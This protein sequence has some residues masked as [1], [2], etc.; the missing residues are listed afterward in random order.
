[1]A[2]G[3]IVRLVVSFRRVNSTLLILYL[4]NIE[5][6]AAFAV[7][8]LNIPSNLNLVSISSVIC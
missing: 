8:G 3:V 6:I 4:T 2:M 7:I 1:M 5:I